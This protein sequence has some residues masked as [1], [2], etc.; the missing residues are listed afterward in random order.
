MI[1]MPF[2]LKFRGSKKKTHY[3]PTDQRTD[4]PSYRDA[5]TH[6]KRKFH[7][8]V[9]IPFLSGTQERSKKISDSYGSR[10]SIPANLYS[11]SS[12]FMT[13]GPRDSAGRETKEREGQAHLCVTESLVY[14]ITE[15]LFSLSLLTVKS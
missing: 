3:G 2:P 1:Y 13:Y 8:R 12:L 6:L 14:L 4:R 5:W 11:R 15:N 10:W 9:A 7:L